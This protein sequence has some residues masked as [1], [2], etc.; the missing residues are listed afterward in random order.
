MNC[1]AFH[2]ETRAC[3][4]IV[5]LYPSSLQFQ[6]PVAKERRW[7]VAPGTHMHAPACAR[8]QVRSRAYALH[9][10]APQGSASVCVKRSAKIT[11]WK[12]RHSRAFGM[13]KECSERGKK[14]EE[15]IDA[16]I[17]KQPDVGGTLEESRES[18]RS[19][20]QRNDDLVNAVLQTARAR[21]HTKRFK[22]NG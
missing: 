15:N 19:R 21:N 8:A 1:Y 5:E 22:G 7:Q 6:R 20:R 16:S 2:L 12:T 14:D 11:K 17:S 4:A 13:I 3:K 9:R 10:A 18:E